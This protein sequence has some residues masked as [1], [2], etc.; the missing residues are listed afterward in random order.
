MTVK[1]R[2][3]GSGD[4]FGSGGRLHTCILIDGETKRY[5]VDCGPSA[6]SAMHRDGIDPN[7]IDAIL[8]THLHGDHYGGVP[9]FTLA[10][11]LM[12]RREAPLTIAGPPGTAARLDVLA[13]ALFPK[14]TE[15]K[16]R[17]EQNVIEY[18]LGVANHIAGV[19]VT[20]YEANHS[21]ESIPQALRIECD[22]KIITYSGDGEWS[23]NL[24]PAGRDADLFIAECYFYDSK[25]PLHMNYH[26]LSA[27]LGEIGAKR[28]ILTHMA[29]QML[30]RVDELPEETAADGLELELA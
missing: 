15:I 13:E 28:V 12:S 26:M 25:V 16:Y 14:M 4:A 23:D 6:L 21:P 11:Q 18:D 29:D 20:P 10:A 5:L 9:F 1:V 2:F 3:L 30:T 22:G 27:R 19:V 8:L 24:I 17:Y 7:S